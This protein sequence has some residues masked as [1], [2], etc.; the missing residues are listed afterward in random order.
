MVDDR[1]DRAELWDQIT[2]LSIENP[3]SLDEFLNP[4]DE[5]IIDKDSDIFA[6]IVEHYSIDKPGEEEE[7][8]D[9]KEEEVEQIEDT[10]VLRIIERLR[11]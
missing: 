6:A 8:S 1:I 7:S 3:L 10:E 2:Q 4:E 9:K 5:I 11:L